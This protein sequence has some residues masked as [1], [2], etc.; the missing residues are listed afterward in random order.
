MKSL[1]SVLAAL[2]VFASVAAVAVSA[3]APPNGIPTHP[4]VSPILPPISRP[5]LAPAATLPPIG[6]P[7][8]GSRVGAVAPGTRVPLSMLP[9]LPMRTFANTV[10]PGRPA[11]RPMSADGSTIAVAGSGSAQCSGS[12]STLFV[13][14]CQVNWNAQNIP[15]GSTYQDYYIAANSSVAT[16]VGGTHGGGAGPGHTTTLS[17]AGIWVFAVFN[18]TANQWQTVVYA[19]AGQTFAL[20]VYQDS[21]H[22]Q[23]SYQYDVNSVSDAYIYATNL[24][25]GD[26]YV[27]YVES[28]S[29][30]PHCIFS[31][32]AQGSYPTTGTG[33]LCNPNSL[34]GIVSSGGTMSVTWPLSV[35]YA[36]GTYVVGIFDTTAKKRLGTVQVA[37]TGGAGITLSVKPDG[38][39]AN[40]SPLPQLPPG[41]SSSVVAWDDGSEQSASGV[42]FATVANLLNHTYTWTLAD[43]T[44]FVA[45]SNTF[46]AGGPQAHTFNFNGAIQSAGGYASKILTGTLYDN[47]LKAVVASQS[48]QVKGYQSLTEFDVAMA[49][50]YSASL[51]VTPGASVVSGLKFVNTGDNYYG[52]GNGDPLRGLLFT[53]GNPRGSDGAFLATA[54]AGN[55]VMASLNGF[56]LASCSPKCTSVA[57]DSNGNSWNLSDFCSGPTVSN[58]GECYIEADPALSST[59]LKPGDSLEIPSMT[60]YYASASACN[61]LPNGACPGDT[62]ILPQDGLTWSTINSQSAWAPVY[63]TDGTSSHSGTGSLAIVGECSGGGG[64]AFNGGEA[65]YYKLNFA[66]AAYNLN[67]P[68]TIPNTNENIYGITVH[69][70]SSGGT[71]DRIYALAFELTGP[72]A[73]PGSL[74]NIGLDAASTGNWQLVTCPAGFLNGAYTCIS[75]AAAGHS[76][77]T[78]GTETIY[79][80]ASTVAQSFT[81]LDIA[82]SSIQDPNS[83]NGFQFSITPATAAVPVFAAG[84]GGLNVDSLAQGLYSLNSG[85]MSYSFAP[86][87]VGANATNF[88][89]DVL[90]T[91][92]PLSSDP[93]PDYIDNVL[94]EVPNAYLTGNTINPATPTNPGWS[95]LGTFTQ[96][97]FHYY[98]FGLCSAQFTSIQPGGAQSTPPP[99]TPLGAL[100]NSVAKC[101]ATEPSALAPGTQ[102][103]MPFTIANAGTANTTWG[104]AVHGANGGGWTSYSNITL[105]NVP[106]SGSGGFASINGTAV[107]TNTE[108]Q[109]SGDPN[110]YVY[111]IKNNST[112]GTNIT[113]LTITIPGTDISGLSATQ[114]G[115]SPWSVSGAA[116]SGTAYGCTVVSTTQATAGGTNGSIVIGGGSCSIGASSTISIQFTATAPGVQNDEFQWPTTISPGGAKMG[117]AWTNDT[118]IKIVDVIGLT[119]VVDP[120]NPGPGGSTPSVNCSACAFSGLT[121]D[122]GN[123][124]ASTQTVGQDVIRASVYAQSS[125]HSSWVLCVDTN[126][127]PASTF[128][129]QTN[130]LQLATDP[131]R[132]TTGVAGLTYYNSTFATIPVIGSGNPELKLATGPFNSAR[133]APYDTLNNL[134]LSIGTEFAS[135]TTSQL[136]YTIIE[137]TAACPNS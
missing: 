80:D 61:G 117:E 122:L 68:Y 124:G 110:T 9:A 55:G 107:P 39:A 134:Q 102:M 22:S 137:D 89:E 106:V 7:V 30:A 48:F 14:G 83:G 101:G 79:F 32:P 119:I 50:T 132:S 131:S 115:V 19:S 86:S 21:F 85:F 5:T 92:T 111:S 104:V 69:N 23:E 3:A 93:N 20:K 4:I 116:I 40:P 6:M 11:L 53:T 70:T 136:T 133:S 72:F 59:V 38:T 82:L 17:S 105:T 52:I 103:S 129:G 135:L 77:A 27:V 125:A 99:T 51:V 56:T 84:S 18:V 114:L 26:G 112:N 58:T 81:Y 64:C 25:P 71:P 90:F 120:S 96:G 33:S 126:N 88:T 74:Y 65:H 91:N 12:T 108:P 8:S 60:F 34:V 121:I 45:A 57:S 118:R 128:P 44:G 24:T 47:T 35:S 31:A 28:T 16:A 109:I 100:A 29:I 73:G 95:Y 46:T 49:G 66:Q 13:V 15:A 37:I 94:V 41:I 42:N 98:D 123:P 54:G 1:R 2:A 97:A 78:G 113:G 76:I 36:P 130:E 87:T 63:F 127:N 10:A 43:P 62:S 75:G 67:T